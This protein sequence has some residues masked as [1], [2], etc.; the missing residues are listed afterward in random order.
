MKVLVTGH[1]GYIGVEMVPV[2]RQAGHEVVGL[3][4]GYYDECDFRAPPDDVPNLNVDLRDI[5]P[6][7]LRGFDAVIHL[8]ALSN[9][10]L[11]NLNPGLTYDI[12]LHASVKLAQAA[13]DAGVS[14][15]LF[16]SSCSLYGAG[17]SGFLD[18]NAAFNPVTAY[19]ES[20]VRVEQEAAKLASSAFSP[21]YLRNAT[22]YGIS[23]R[24]RA[25]IVV[26]NLVGHA[27]TTGK[28]LLQ[29]DGTPWRPLV[30]IRDIIHAFE[31]MLTAPKELIHN[32][33]FNV[34]RTSENFQ[35]RDVANMVAEIVPNCAVSFAVGASADARDYRVDFS[36]IERLPGFHPT[37]TLRKGI[38]EMY[39]AY[40]DGEMT[41]EEFLG[42][43]YY[44]LRT[45]QGLQERG[46]LD[47]NLR[48]KS[49]S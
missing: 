42:P 29:S 4:A 41:A 27:L 9:D 15:F 39:R 16:S 12:N 47:V 37:W 31:T 5:T 13:K 26:N 44:R 28:V 8:A 21:V 6:E 14:R 10:P 3:D 49:A 17:G 48:R 33:A 23:R 45:V 24:L 11:G 34:G 20:K 32:Q 18:E 38:E 1:R 7:P 19:G 22:A 40:R 36:K 43:R 35:I 46:S 30:H 2:L 25:D